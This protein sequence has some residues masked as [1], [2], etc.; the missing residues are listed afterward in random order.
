MFGSLRYL[1]L[2]L[3]GVGGGGTPAEGRSTQLTSDWSPPYHPLPTGPHSQPHCP[4][5]LSVWG[6]L[7]GNQ[8]SIQVYCPGKTGRQAGRQAW[9]A[10]VYNA[11]CK[12]IEPHF[13]CLSIL[14]V[15]VCV[16]IYNLS[17]RGSGARYLP[18]QAWWGDILSCLL[19]CAHVCKLVCVRDTLCMWVRSCPTCLCY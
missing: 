2:P 15:Y 8:W 3:E 7:P 13:F 18:M 9:G 12:E 17:W 1:P 19:E 6:R 14:V 4:D 11:A 5:R 16:S 10:G